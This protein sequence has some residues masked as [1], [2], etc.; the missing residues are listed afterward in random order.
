[1]H[2]KRF[3]LP[4]F[5]LKTSTKEFRDTIAASIARYEKYRYWASKGSTIGC[6]ARARH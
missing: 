5:A 2:R 6:L 3:R 1:M 4:D